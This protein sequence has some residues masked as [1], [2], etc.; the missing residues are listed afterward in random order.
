MYILCCRQHTVG[1]T[2]TKCKIL[3]G[4]RAVQV[5]RQLWKKSAAL[6]V[7][8]D[9]PIGG[10]A[11]STNWRQ[12]VL[13]LTRFSPSAGTPQIWL[14]DIF[15]CQVLSIFFAWYLS[16]VGVRQMLYY[17]FAWYLCQVFS[18]YWARSEWARYGIF[19]CL[20]SEPVR[21]GPGGLFYFCL[22]SCARYA[23]R[24]LTVKNV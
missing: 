12:I 15:L 22:V 4:I 24:Q 9:S 7:T 13:R 19:F 6:Q 1:K 2:A 23:V 17:F 18:C 8:H 14:L 21:S 16:Q 10:K 11:P 20:I 3:R 5:K